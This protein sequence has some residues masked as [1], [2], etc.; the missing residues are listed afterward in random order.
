M[1]QNMDIES[2]RMVCNVFYK[3]AGRS[4][5]S[6]DENGNPFVNYKFQGLLVH[7]LLDKTQ[8]ILFM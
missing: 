7:D 4:P 5:L 2:S 8:A 6:H 1:N 3:K